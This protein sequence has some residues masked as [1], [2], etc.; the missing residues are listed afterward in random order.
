[1]SQYYYNPFGDSKIS[2]ENQ[3]A[4]LKKQR[5]CKER[6]EILLISLALGGAIITYLIVQSFVVTLLAVTGYYS[7]FQSDVVFQTAVTIIG[8]SFM[9]VFVPFAIMALVN[10]K[11]YA[12]PVIP[13]EPIK[14]SKCMMWIA[15]G[16]LCCIGANITVSY[17][18]TALE[19]L[20]D[21]EFTQGELLEPNSVF[22]CVMV[23]VSTAIIPAIC[24]EFAMRCCSL[25]LLRKYGSGFAVFAV[26]I[27]FGLLHGNVIQFI[28]AF[29]IGLVLGFITVKTNSIVPAVCIHAFSN[30][31][32][33]TKSV[34]TYAA[35]EETANTSVVILYLLWLAAGAISG[36]VL[37]L[38]GAFKKNKTP[39]NSVLSNAQKL[40]YFMIPMII[41]FAILIYLTAKTIVK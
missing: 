25:Q 28:F 14:F 35:G 4:F 34:V 20:F 5:K 12:Y 19:A 8:V 13:N 9:A 2:E 22:G 27:V 3:R 37:L 36:F 26:S 6:N 23:T 15:F 16:M 40:L 21:V 29:I 41:P 17:L 38:K 24:E 31:I 18:I 33:V 32:S 11:R 10:R 30:G 1:L 39:V 7:K